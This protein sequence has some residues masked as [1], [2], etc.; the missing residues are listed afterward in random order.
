MPSKTFPKQYLMDVLNGDVE[1]C[2]IEYDEIVDHGRWTLHHEMIFKDVDGLFYETNYDIG[3]TEY[4]DERPFEN[5]DDLV[6]CV[7]VHQVPETTMVWKAV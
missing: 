4:Q 7:Q 2:S 3:A 6:K 5:A 1:G